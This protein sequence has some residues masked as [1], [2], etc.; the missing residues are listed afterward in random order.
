MKR[1]S[2]AALILVPLL[3]L[4]SCTEDAILTIYNNTE[5]TTEIVIESLEHYVAPHNTLEKRWRLSRT[6]FS[7]EEMRLTVRVKEKLFLFAVEFTARLRAGSRLYEEIEY[8]AAGLEIYND[9]ASHIKEIY[10]SPSTSS[11]WG[12]NR[13]IGNL[14]PYEYKRWNLTPGFWDIKVVNVWG[15]SFIAYDQVFYIG[16]LRRYHIIGF[17]GRDDYKPEKNQTSP[18]SPVNHSSFSQVPD[19]GLPRCEAI[20]PEKN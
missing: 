20:S 14:T 3:L 17:T 6:F 5:S 10:I 12:S 18:V 13:L 19:I 4:T 8:N 9:S 16:E 2:L 7:A 1:L 15:E 11:F